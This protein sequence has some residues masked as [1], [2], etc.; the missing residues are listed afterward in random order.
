[1]NRILKQLTDAEDAEITRAAQSDSDAPPLTDEDLAKMKP[2]N[3]MLPKIFGTKSAAGLMRRS[4][5]PARPVGYRELYAG[6]RASLAVD[7]LIRA[8]S[9]NERTKATRWAELW[10]KVAR[11]PASLRRN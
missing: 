6:R 7:R 9:E 8:K 10:G 1:M 2:A 4:P 11:F 5:R 3:E